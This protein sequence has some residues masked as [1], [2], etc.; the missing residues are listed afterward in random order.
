MMKEWP[1]YDHNK[2]QVWN[3]VKRRGRGWLEQGRH[4]SANSSKWADIC[5]QT[6]LNQ[7]APVCKQL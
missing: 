7:Q 1:L 4:L 2:V 5:L 6:A 3:G